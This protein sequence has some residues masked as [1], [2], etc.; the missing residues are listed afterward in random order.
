M[1]TEIGNADYYD[2]SITPLQP[3]ETKGLLVYTFEDGR[4]EHRI[5]TE[6]TVNA[7]EAEP[8]MNP[9][10]NDMFPYPGMYPG[11]EEQTSKFPLIP[12]IIGGVVLVGVLFLLL[13]LKDAR[14]EKS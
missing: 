11:M 7:M 1:G 12:V 3:G 13:F 14:K 8:V 2:A 10:P 9:F 6:F 5:E 4:E